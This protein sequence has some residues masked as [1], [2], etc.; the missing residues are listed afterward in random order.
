MEWEIV[1][2]LMVRVFGGKNERR[3]K[4]EISNWGTKKFEWDTIFIELYVIRFY[5][6]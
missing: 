4:T 6:I 2:W 3:G 5:K 1:A